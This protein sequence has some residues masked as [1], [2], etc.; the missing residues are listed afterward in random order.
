MIKLIIFCLFS[1]IVSCAQY[2]N[3]RNIKSSHTAY[4]LKDKVGNFNL[5]RRLKVSKKKLI[6]KTTINST[7]NNDLPVEKTVSVSQVD[8]NLLAPKI[9]Q[10]TVWLEKKEYFSQ[11]KLSKEKNN[12]EILMKSPEDKWNG[13]KNISIPKAKFVCF[14]SQLPECLKFNG[15]LEVNSKA[16]DLLIIWDSYPY[17]EE[18]YANINPEPY[19]KATF[20]FVGDSGGLKKYNLNLSNQFIF[21]VFDK[22]ND[23]EKMYWI[24]QGITQIRQGQNAKHQ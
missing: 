16:K 4:S 2:N 21:Y 1:A 18:I 13:K 24:A 15:L 10:Y 17:H 14:F 22:N 6:T 20:E 8:N 23:F 7:L 12:L 9:S 19:E 3:Y 5:E 11:V